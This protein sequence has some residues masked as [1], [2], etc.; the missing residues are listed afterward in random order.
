MRNNLK[1]KPHT[2][3]FKFKVAIKSLKGEQ[4]IA[5]LCQE[6]GVVSSQIYDW[7]KD[8]NTGA[9]ERN[10]TSDLLITNRTP[11]KKYN[12]KIPYYIRHSGC[13][14]FCL[15]SIVTK[16]SPFDEVS[17]FFHIVPTYHLE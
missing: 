1:K 11:Y 6:F 9:E 5:K 13:H 8:V 12:L 4:T 15:I 16:L 17:F 3:E 2:A 10:R 7:R 14:H